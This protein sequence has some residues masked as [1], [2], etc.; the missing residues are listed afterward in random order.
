M[1]NVSLNGYIGS[2]DRDTKIAK[3]RNP[4]GILVSGGFI[5]E[6]IV[7]CSV[8]NEDL[9]M[10]YFNNGEFVEI[11]GFLPDNQTRADVFE[12]VASELR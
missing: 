8:I 7:D 1:T 11:T 4:Q 2:F 6:A 12:A 10:H 3:L 5:T 9:V